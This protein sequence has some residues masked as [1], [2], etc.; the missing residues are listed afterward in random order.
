MIPTMKAVQFEDYGEVEVLQV[1]VVPRPSPKPV[2][3]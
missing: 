2:K 3:S 1:R